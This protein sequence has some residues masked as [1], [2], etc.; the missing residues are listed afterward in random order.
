MAN[1]KQSTDY[2]HDIKINVLGSV[3]TMPFVFLSFQAFFG[4]EMSLVVEPFFAGIALNH[5]CSVRHSAITPHVY[6]LFC[7]NM[8]AWSI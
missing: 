6:A 8:A 1:K 3:F 7:N 4:I 5:Q 2:I